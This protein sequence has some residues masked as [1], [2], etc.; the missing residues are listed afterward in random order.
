MSAPSVTAGP[1]LRVRVWV[2][3]VWDTVALSLTPE[4]TI[5]ELKATALARATGRP[6]RAGAHVVK[7]RGAMVSDERQTLAG[8]GVPDGAPF[9]VLPARRQPV[10]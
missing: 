7:Y 4:S 3:D 9:I 2:M 1:A 10:R 6:E 8:L 5:A